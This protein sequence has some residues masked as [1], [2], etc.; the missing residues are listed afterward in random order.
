[1]LIKVPFI[2]CAKNDYLSL[3]SSFKN[4]CVSG[5]LACLFVTSW[6]VAHQA[7][8]FIRFSRQEY[9]NGSPFSSPG[10]LLTQGSKQRSP[11]LQADS[12]PSELPGKPSENI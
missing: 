5:T 1:M 3:W 10:D 2:R 9:W 4:L 11:A 8:L 7:P 12:L 6:T